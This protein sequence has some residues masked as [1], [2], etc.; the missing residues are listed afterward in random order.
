MFVRR[1]GD[2][3]EGA[4]ADQR[5]MGENQGALAAHRI[6]FVTIPFGHAPFR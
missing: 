1:Q 5:G 6:R 4:A 2:H 3:L